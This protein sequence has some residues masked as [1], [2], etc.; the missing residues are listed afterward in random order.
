M[1]NS[2]L[3][4]EFLLRFCCI[5]RVIIDK[6]NKGNDILQI[7]YFLPYNDIASPNTASLQTRVTDCLCEH[8]GN[9]LLRGIFS[10]QEEGRPRKYATKE[11]IASPNHIPEPI[12]G[13]ASTPRMCAKAE[14]L[15]MAK[16]GKVPTAVRTKKLRRN[17]RRLF[18]DCPFNCYLLGDLII[19]YRVACA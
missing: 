16:R 2:L 14:R 5:D 13:R 17:E 4:V 10:L 12:R 1:S 11:A 19:K 15:S 3:C 9:T 6:T 7:V 18:I 8:L